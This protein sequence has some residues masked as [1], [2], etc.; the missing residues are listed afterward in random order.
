MAPSPTQMI[1]YWKPW[2]IAGSC[3]WLLTLILTACLQGQGAVIPVLVL[4]VAGIPLFL[5]KLALHAGIAVV[6]LT[7]V[8]SLYQPPA[9]WDVI[10]DLDN[11]VRDSFFKLRGPLAPS[12]DVIVVDIDRKS[13]EAIGQWPWPRTEVANAIRNMMADGAKVIGFDIVFAEPDRLSIKDWLARIETMGG[14]VTLPQEG[15]Q[16]Y[17]SGSAVKN[18]ILKDWQRTLKRRDPSFD[19]D[20]SDSETVARYLDYQKERWEERQEVFARRAERAGISYE[21]LP[22][23]KLD[24]PLGH[25]AE[26]SRELF[27]LGFQGS[28]QDMLRQGANLVLDNDEELGKAFALGPVVAGG[29]FITETSAGSRIA[30]YRRRESN[31]ETAGMVVSAAFNDGI[32]EHFPYLREALEQVNNV[33]SVQALA[34]HQGMFNVV[35]DRSGAV[36]QYSMLMK[37]PVFLST[38]VPKQGTE[39]LSGLAVLDP[40]N[41]ENKI[42][43]HTYTYPSL[44]LEMLRAANGYDAVTP[45]KHGRQRGLELSRNRGFSYDG[46]NT[47]AS[48][49][50]CFIPLDKKGE[51]RINFLGYGGPWQPESQHGPE[52]F[53]DYVSLSDV[54]FHRFDPGTFHDKYVLV[55]S[56]DPTLSDHVGSPYRAAFPG[57]EVHATVLDNLLKERSIRDLGGFSRA[58]TFLL[59]LLGGALLAILVAYAAPLLGVVATF[60]FLIGLPTLSFLAFSRYGLAIDFV[61]PWL[62]GAFLTAVGMMTNFFVEGRDRRFVATQFAKMVSPDILSRLQQDPQGISFKGQRCD[63]TVMFIDLEGFTTMSEKLEATRLV[64]LINAYLNPVSELIMRN[65][66]FIDKFIGD[67]VMACWGVPYPD[68][69]HAIQACRTALDQ[70]DLIRKLSPD[71]EKTYGVE[72]HCRTGIASGE[73]CAAF[74]GSD[75]RKSYTVVGDAVNLSARIEPAC[76]DYGVKILVA[77]D[78]YQVAKDE[79]E[80]RKLDFLVVKGKSIPVAI[81]ELVGHKGSLSP[82]EKLDIVHYEEALHLHQERQWKEALDKLEELLTS[83]PDNVAASSLK[84]RIHEYQVTP[85]PEA[86]QGEFI[87]SRKD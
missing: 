42:V 48:T 22:F 87:R 2:R 69:Q 38:L 67:A 39:E 16:R 11:R 72:L 60:A 56:S 4:L 34:H 40:N 36:R 53:F 71:F 37:A 73:V 47:T 82:Q 81:Y 12:K 64:E 3:I 31:E 77:E 5:D 7:S 20:N 84:Q 24:D 62:S 21:P 54:L 43:S 57:L 51:M 66:G 13:V 17:L 1:R 30:A 14:Q 46:A 19:F 52:H 58:F 83:D 86:W 76:K 59:I 65:H 8:V 9:L 75:D 85:P 28:R 33:G 68:Q 74:M 15:S 10:S 25:M 35:P 44:A 6:L 27:Y 29:L 80:F 18:I 55:G 79:F 45:V 32:D 23:P 78:S 61:Y 49:D 26:G 70:Q 50:P 63:V 41:Y